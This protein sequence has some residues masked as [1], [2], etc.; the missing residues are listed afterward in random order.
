MVLHAPDEGALYAA[1]GRLGAAA[2]RPGVD[3]RVHNCVNNA[4]VVPRALGPQLDT[5]YQAVHSMFPSIEVGAAIPLSTLHRA[6]QSVPSLPASTW[7]PGLQLSAAAVGHAKTAQPLA[8][9][10]V[11][12]PVT[13]ARGTWC[14][15]LWCLHPGARAV[16][17]QNAS[18]NAMLPCLS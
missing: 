13:P 12:M 8:A 3:L 17:L 2:V 16:R 10:A 5:M 11:K 15:A 14:T 4:D 6:V 7:Q 1:L 9:G 18:C